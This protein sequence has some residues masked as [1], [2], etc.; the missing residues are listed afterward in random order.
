MTG[1][2]IES[3]ARLR[4]PE[5]SE[6]AG[7]T[8]RELYVVGGQQRGLRPVL[9]HFTGNWYEYKKAVALHVDVRT[10]VTR[11]VAEWTTPAA[12]A[13][14]ENP[15][16]LYKSGTLVGDRL[17]VTTQTEV[18][19][20][21]VPSFELE[22][23]IS[24]PFFNDVHHARPTPDGNVLVA[25]TGLDMVAEVTHGGDLVRSWNVHDPSAG[26]WGGRFSPEVDYRLVP[27]TKPHLA[28]PNH[29]F[30]IGDEPWATRFEQRDAI[31]LVDP[32][33]RIDIGVERLHDGVVYGDRVLFT[34]VNG[35]VVIADTRTLQVT[36]V[37]DLTTMHESDTMLGWCRGLM[38]DGDRLWIGFS[39]MRPTKF[40]ENVAWVRNGF[41]H[42]YGTHVGLYDLN[43]RRC[44]AQID[45]E[46][47]GL[48]AVFGIFPAG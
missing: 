5:T 6:P 36:E 14:P 28:H 38:L 43:E 31:S 23:R 11:Q 27:T 18:L 2:A 3:A 39:H 47:G 20:Y 46:Q 26:I 41:R 7:S 16:V 24:P 17:Y 45:L 21:R 37:I 25:V 13:P 35:K 34:A 42:W 19:I 9:A 10:G 44:L 8:V 30:Y 32:S 40:R 33:R 48:N 29:V 15:A 4:G 1:T 12:E 22:T